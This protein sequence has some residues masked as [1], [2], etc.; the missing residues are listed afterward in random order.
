MKINGTWKLTSHCSAT[1][2][3]DLVILIHAQVTRTTPELA[4]SSP[5]FHSTPTGGYLSLDRFNVHRSST[6]RVFSGTWIKLMT[7]RPRVRYLGHSAA[8]PMEISEKI[9]SRDF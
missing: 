2:A 5:N 4:P 7:R 3:T 6:R 9:D 1:R 8:A